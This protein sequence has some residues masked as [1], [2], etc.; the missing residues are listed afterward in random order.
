MTARRNPFSKERVLLLHQLIAEATG[1]SVGLWEVNGIRLGCT[2]E[3]VVELGPG[4]AV[5]STDYKAL[6]DWVREHR[7]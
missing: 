4:V 2:N 5:G 7:I 6:L 1:G 3:D